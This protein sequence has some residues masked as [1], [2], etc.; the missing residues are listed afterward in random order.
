[1]RRLR[2]ARSRHIQHGC[3]VSIYIGVMDT[4]VVWRETYGAMITRAPGAGRGPTLSMLSGT[5]ASHLS[6]WRVRVRGL[7]EYQDPA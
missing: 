1:M 2:T 6:S 7:S 5:C 4:D 3:P